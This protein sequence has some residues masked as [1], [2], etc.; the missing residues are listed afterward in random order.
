MR[1]LTAC[2]VLVVVVV[3]VC[4][5]IKS[6]RVSLLVQCRGHTNNDNGIPNSWE[7]ALIRPLVNPITGG[8]ARSP[9]I[10]QVLAG[11]SGQNREPGTSVVSLIPNPR[12]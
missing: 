4:V 8:P 10:S 12:W 5:T 7:G 3:A 9:A 6:T 1:C 11:M 2:W